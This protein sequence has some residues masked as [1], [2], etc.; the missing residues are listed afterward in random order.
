MLSTMNPH[1]S[2]RKH[3]P[4]S[5]SFFLLFVMLVF[6][7]SKNHFIWIRTILYS[8]AKFCQDWFME[9]P[10]EKNCPT[11]CSS[12]PDLLPTLTCSAIPNCESVGSSPEVFPWSPLMCRGSCCQTVSTGFQQWDKYVDSRFPTV[13]LLLLVFFKSE[14]NQSMWIRILYF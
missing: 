12:N 14:I 2:V 1:H 7:T 8:K 9:F 6:Y 4:V 3:Q 13:E 10:D 11:S 5:N